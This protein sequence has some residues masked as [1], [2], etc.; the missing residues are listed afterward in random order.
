MRHTGRVKSLRFRLTI[1]YILIFGL[2]LTAI[3]FTFRS[4]LMTII[5]DRVEEAVDEDWSAARGFLKVE[6]G[7]AIWSVDPREVDRTAFLERL[8]RFVMVADSHG[9]VLEMSI[10]YRQQG[11]ESAAEI[12]ERF[13][14]GSPQLVVKEQGKDR[15]LLR[16]GVF[17]SEG[18]PYLLVV[19]RRITDVGGL[20]T[21]FMTDYFTV[22]PLLLLVT[23][24]LGWF[25]AGRALIPV[26]R[27]AE[28]AQRISGSS[29]HLR[30]SRRF[31][32]DELEQLIVAFNTMM[33]R[34]SENFEQVRRFSTDVSHELRTPLTA[35]RGQLEVALMTAEKEDDFR[36][37]IVNA[38]EDVDRI[39]NIVR[40]LLLLSQAETGQLALH[41]DPVN[42]TEVVAELAEQF[43]TTAKENG[44]QLAWQLDHDVY[45]RG[46]RT[47]MDRLVS[48]LLSNALK[49][50]PSGGHV[51][52]Q[53]RRG[54][55][56][57]TA[58]LTVAD[59]G[60]GIPPD[61]L[62]HIFDRFY[63]VPGEDPDKGLGLGL[64]FVNWIVKAHQGKIDV[65]SAVGRG[66]TFTIT[67]PISL[68]H[69]TDEPAAA[70]SIPLAEARQ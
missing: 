67:L 23:G 54:E 48:N 59:D 16:Y 21:A 52:V 39:S 20:P 65:T 43:R 49:Y 14:E 40:A 60:K 70:V 61:S 63:R 53:V 19:G 44:L 45:V 6:R 9:E 64:S 26:N 5:Q 34:L 55:D 31:A 30:I 8:R 18:T 32:N 24:V 27:V 69:A 36:E 7:Q 25:M 33:E 68:S 11:V 22:V 66:T 1:S 28:A 46:D 13:K 2:L 51:M 37:A 62:P 4:R 17:R 57:E 58:V 42:L 35:I 38:L 56:S 3:G 50:T 15:V 12:M 10:G 41:K 29:L 47:Q